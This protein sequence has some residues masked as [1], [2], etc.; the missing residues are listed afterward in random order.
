LTAAI[1][2]ASAG[3]AIAVIKFTAEHNGDLR[4]R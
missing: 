3:A 1:N 4:R 2:V